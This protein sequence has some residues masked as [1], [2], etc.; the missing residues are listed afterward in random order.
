MP[1]FD[2]DF[3]LPR[4]EGEDILD[5]FDRFA[6][7]LKSVDYGPNGNLERGLLVAI[8]IGDLCEAE[9]IGEILKRKNAAQMK[10]IK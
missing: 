5:Y 1:E 3:D 9:R 8:A 6:A 7:R 2:G 4:L 10:I